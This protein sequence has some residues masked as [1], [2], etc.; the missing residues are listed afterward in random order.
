MVFLFDLK[1]I[2]FWSISGGGGM[3]ILDIPLDDNELR[4]EKLLSPFSPVRDT[5]HFTS[6][7]SHYIF[8]SGVHY[9][10]LEAI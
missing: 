7:L 2:D 1:E 6:T 3:A 10:T 9:W 5:C 4:A 8:F